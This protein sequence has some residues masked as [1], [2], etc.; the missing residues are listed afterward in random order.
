MNFNNKTHIRNFSLTT[1]PTISANE[2]DNKS[3]VHQMG[4]II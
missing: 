2:N 1:Q 4:Y 3:D